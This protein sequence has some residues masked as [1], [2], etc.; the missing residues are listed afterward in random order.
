LARIAVRF[1][2][3]SSATQLTAAHGKENSFAASRQALA[4]VN[5]LHAATAR[6][7][8]A[9]QSVKIGPDAYAVRVETP[10]DSDADDVPAKFRRNVNLALEVLGKILSQP[11]TEVTSKADRRLAA[12]AAAITI[13][14]AIATDKNVLKAP[15]A[16]FPFALKFP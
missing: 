1:V 3:E 8:E 16:E 2:A 7:S 11:I 4:I 5:R 13:K 9:L 12:K 10:T 6:R 14:A 15:R